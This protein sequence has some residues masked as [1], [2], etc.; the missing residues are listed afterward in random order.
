MQIS[1]VETIFCY[2]ISACLTNLPKKFVIMIIMNLT[3]GN[4]IP[5]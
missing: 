4:H 1:F 3:F 5:L 2:S